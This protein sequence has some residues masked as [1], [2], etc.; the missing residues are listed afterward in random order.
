MIPLSFLIHKSCHCGLCQTFTSSA[1]SIGLVVPGNAFEISDPQNLLK[2]YEEAGA[3]NGV[4]YR[5]AF[6][7]KCGCYLLH[8]P[9]YIL[10]RSVLI[11]S[12]ATG[13]MRILTG[14]LDPGCKGFVDGPANEIHVQTRVN[15]LPE[16]QGTQQHQS[17]PKWPEEWS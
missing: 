12:I 9:V 15:W 3:L 17:Y 16:I 1:F 8:E 10:S 5:I 6:C 11:K 13:S 14:T 7:S 2:V 4:G